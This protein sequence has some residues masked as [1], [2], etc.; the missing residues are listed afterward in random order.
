MPTGH[1]HNRRGR[2]GIL[3]PAQDPHRETS[4]RRHTSEPF[5]EHP[6]R[7]IE[8]YRFSCCASTGHVPC[9]SKAQWIPY[10]HL[11]LDPTTKPLF[12]RTLLPAHWLLNLG[13][14]YFGREKSRWNTTVEPNNKITVHSGVRP[15][16]GLRVLLRRATSTSWQTALD[17]AIKNLFGCNLAV[18]K[19]DQL[20]VVELSTLWKLESVACAFDQFFAWNVTNGN[21]SLNFRFS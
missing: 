3:D 5:Q 2:T 12:Q 16:T 13:S 14:F 18:A 9:P 21:L 11:S 19:P 1:I 10:R 7:N 4:R 20:I 15:G 6:D 17:H 8:K